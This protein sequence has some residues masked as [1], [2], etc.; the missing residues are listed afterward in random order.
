MNFKRTKTKR[1]VKC[2]MCTSHR[3]LG[4]NKSRFKAKIENLTQELNKEI[5]N[6]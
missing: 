3:W 1:N 5:K 6:V 4:N 2:T